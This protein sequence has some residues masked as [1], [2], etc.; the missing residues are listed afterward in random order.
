MNGCCLRCLI[1]KLFCSKE[2]K[3]QCLKDSP[4]SPLEY[5]AKLNVVMKSEPGQSY[6]EN[7]QCELVYGT[8]A[9]ICPYMV[10]FPVTTML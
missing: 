4:V 9:K 8:G 5:Q 6:S 7:V 2:Y 3:T 1:I 10:I